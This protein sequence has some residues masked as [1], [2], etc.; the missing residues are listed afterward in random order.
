MGSFL[1]V[2]LLD[3]AVPRDRKRFAGVAAGR[4]AHD[5]EA[6]RSVEKILDDVRRRGDRAVFDCARRFDGVALNARTIRF[7]PVTFPALAREVPAKLKRAIRASA[8]RIRAYHRRQGLPRF[9]MR[10]AEGRLGQITRPLERVGVYVP[11][12]Y[13]VYPSSLL[14][15]VI[16]AQLAGV[17]EIVAVTPGKGGLDPNLAFAFDYLGI[18]EVYRMGG[19]HAIG[20]LAYGSR[21]VRPVEKVVGPGNLYVAL[22]KKAVYGTVDI[23]M[24]AGPSEVAVLADSTAD[25]RHVALDMLAQAEHGTGDEMAVCVTESRRAAQRIQ[26]CLVEEIEKSEVKDVFGRLRPGGLCICLTKSRSE[27][28]ELVNRIAPEHLQIITKRPRSDLKGVRNAAA[29]FLGKHTPVALGDYFVGTNHVLPTGGASRFASALGVDDF[30]KRIS[31]AEVSARG[32]KSAAPHVS[33]FA[34]AEGFVHHALSVENRL[35]K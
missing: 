25:P 7:D 31:V 28:L 18:T 27:S 12:G 23:D 32:L 9:S 16:P 8:S 4:E 1:S 30:L 21:S 15:N 24:V 17:K 13:T 29:V 33:A 34:R 20:A 35:K 19:A 14:M 5:R 10:T 26:S 6:Q 11:G 22:A 3:L 2:P